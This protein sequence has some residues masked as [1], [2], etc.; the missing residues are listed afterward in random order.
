MVGWLVA[1]TGAIWSWP[2]TRTKVCNPSLRACA[3]W[4]C[5]GPSTWWCLVQVAQ[6]LQQDVGVQRANIEE[7]TQNS[8]RY[9]QYYTIGQYLWP[10]CR[11]TKGVA[12][13]AAVLGGLSL[14][15]VRQVY[16]V[17]LS[18]IFGMYYKC[19]L[20]SLSCI[21][22]WLATWLTADIFSCQENFKGRIS[23]LR[24]TGWQRQ[25]SFSGKYAKGERAPEILNFWRPQRWA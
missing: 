9:I 4:C 12:L 22:V 25:W 8:K 24:T 11:S 5:T 1:S 6:A 20:C 7:Q 16:S 15:V 3:S 10:R 17:D 21:R 23:S 13:G 18:C 19:R 14:L 2:I